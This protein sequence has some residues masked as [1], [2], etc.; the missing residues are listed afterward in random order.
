MAKAKVTESVKTY[1]L[2]LN[3]DEAEAIY[4]LTGLVSGDA[5]GTARAYTSRVRSALASVGLSNLASEIGLT[6]NI[7]A[8]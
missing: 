3:Q 6:G 2:E 5:F 4:G 7:S 8:N 1:T